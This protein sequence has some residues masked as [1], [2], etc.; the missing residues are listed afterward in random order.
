MTDPHLL[1]LH[2]ALQDD[3]TGKRRTEVLARLR[4]LHNDCLFAQRALCDRETF[5]RLEASTLAVSAA[6]RIIESI[7][8]SGKSRN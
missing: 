8:N 6:M 5:K 4:A 7:P 1:E 3:A 2:S